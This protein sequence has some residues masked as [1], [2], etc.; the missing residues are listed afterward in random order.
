MGKSAYIWGAGAMGRELADVYEKWM[1][2]NKELQIIG[3]VDRSIEKQGQYIHNYCVE[4]PE[5][6][7]DHK[8]DYIII[9]TLERYY[10]EISQDLVSKY[11]YSTDQILTYEKIKEEATEFLR[12]ALIDKYAAEQDKEIRET[13]EYL[14]SSK[15]TLFNQWLTEDTYSKV[16]YDSVEGY[17]YIWFEDKKM[18][19][20]Q[21][22]NFL[23]KDG[24]RYAVN[25][26]K[27]QQ[28]EQSPH[29]YCPKGHEVLKNS[30][31]VD[32]G[33]CEGNF[34]LKYV[35]DAKKIYLVECDPIWQKPLQLTFS[36]FHDK[37]TLVNKFISRRSAYYEI[38]IDDMLEG[39]RV[40]F[41]KA[42]VEGAE[43]DM[44]L[45]AKKTLQ[46]SNAR[47][48]VCSYHKQNDEENIRWILESYGY[49]T[50]A[51]KGN[52]VFTYDPDIY[53]SPEF[54]HGVVYGK[55]K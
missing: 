11:E 10:S 12:R 14:R 3:Y 31:I 32:A 43:I 53:F 8:A 7:K 52:M 44:L 20:P 5:V 6:L 22:Y 48:S 2:A 51:S 38:S 23:V 34:A 33:V 24:E 21:N 30:V 49:E 40:D 36:V 54:R 29:L 45:G 16:F 26:F 27:E 18:Y 28:S 47:I 9:G 4:D 42:D 25:V 1:L 37:V 46:R 17:P 50:S 55:R 19:Y 41:I 35:E 15:L 39:G 13:V